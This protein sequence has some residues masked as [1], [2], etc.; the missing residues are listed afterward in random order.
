M[1]LI[2][3][4]GFSGLKIPRVAD[5]ALK[6]VRNLHEN[7]WGKFPND[8]RERTGRTGERT[9]YMEKS[10]RTIDGHNFWYVRGRKTRL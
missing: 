4:R 7:N 10:V 1:P 5:A 8:E 3:R 9:G 6:K 2:S